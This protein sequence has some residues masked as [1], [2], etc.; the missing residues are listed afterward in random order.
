MKIFERAY[1]EPK[2]KDGTLKSNKL[3]GDFEIIKGEM[4]GYSYV[5]YAKNND[6]GKL[7]KIIGREVSG[8]Y[9]PGEG[10]TKNFIE[11]LSKCEDVKIYLEN[12]VN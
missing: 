8:F 6:D 4:D 3:L 1:D 2:N 5:V 7:Y 12:K 11:E 10:G 9:H